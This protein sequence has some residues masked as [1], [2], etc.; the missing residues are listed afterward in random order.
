MS[1]GPHAALAAARALAFAVLGLAAAGAPAATYTSASTPYSLIPSAGHAKLGYNTTPYRFNGP[2]NCGTVPP[3]L[4][5][6]ISDPIPIGFPFAFGTAVH[7][8]VRVMTN[9]RV[10][11]GNTVC[12][13]GTKSIGPPQTYPNTYPDA[14]MNATMKVFGV[15]LDP[16]NLVDRPN[17]PSSAHR[18][19]C[20]NIASCYVSYATI[21]SAPTRRFVVTWMNVPEWVNTTNTSGSFDLQV[22]LD[23]D[24]SFV[25]Q[26][27][28]ISHGGTGTA[29]VGW[30]LTNA[31][32]EVLSF[33]ASSEPPPYTAIKFYLPAPIA[34]HLFD[35]GAWAPGLAGQVLD[36]TASRHGSAL[37][38]VQTTSG[39][40]LCRAASVPSN[41]SAAAVD[42]VRTGVALTDAALSLLGK[43]TVAFWYRANTAWSGAG[44][45]AAQ[46]LDATAVSGEWFYLAKTAAGALVFEVRD[47]AGTTRAVTSAAQSFAA[48]TWVHVAVTWDF[49][50]NPGPNQDRLQIFV[51][52]GMPA[53]SA[54][55]S[56]GLVSS[57]VGTLH[58]GDNPSGFSGS[59]GSVNS[60]DG[61]VDEVSIYNFSLTQSQLNTLM[62][63][64]RAC[65]TP[66][67]DHLRLQHASGSGVTCTPATLTI[68]AC[69][70]A[71][72]ATPY[73]GGVAGTLTAAGTPTVNFDG[74]TGHGAGARFVIPVGAGSV[75]KALQVT[76]PGSIVVGTNGLSPAASAATTCNFGSPACSFTAA[77]SG[78]VFSVPDHAADSVQA[79]SVSAVRTSP[80][81]LACTPAFASVS[82]SITFACAYADPASGTLPVLLGGTALNAAGNAAAACDTGGKAVSLAFDASGVAPTTLRYADVGRVTL[83]ARHAPTTG[84]EAGLV[85]QGS[86]AFVARPAAF[87][88]GGVR[89][90][91]TA[92]GHC[93]G[94]LAP[95]G[96]NP[97]AASAGGAAFMPAGRAFSATVTA[98]NVSGAA[99]PNFG[100]ESAPEGVVLVATL[101]QPAG[102]TNGTLSNATIA[103]AGFSAGAATVT[104]L[105]YG[106]VG[107]VTLTPA[108]ADGSYLG[109]GNISG[110]V[111]APIGRFVPARF[112]LS[113]ASVAHRSALACAPASTF[114]YLGETFRFALTLTAQNAGGGTTT[115]YAGAFARFDPASAAAWQ[116]TG[117]DGSTVF[118]SASGRLSLGSASGGFAN[119]VAANVTITAAALRASAPEGPFSAAFGIAPVDSDGVALASFDMASASGGANDR[120][121]LGTLALHFGRLR[122]GSAIGAADRALVLPAWVQHWNGSAWDTNT[123]DSCTSVPTAAVSFG[124]LRRTLTT[125][126]TAAS[127]PITFTAGAG[128]LRLAAPGG[129][130]S[131]SV[132]VA[133][134]LGSGA[135]DASCLQL[136]APGSGDAASAGAQLAHLRGAWCGSGNAFDPSARA[137]FGLQRTQDHVLYRRENY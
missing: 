35:E 13:F 124:N 59:A 71:A 56:S 75:S 10:Q 68:V 133:L 15:D 1:R 66:A 94:T 28:D 115:N 84:T 33:G 130:R 47:S 127:G 101:L 52:A 61:L 129:G 49:N 74:S 121:S 39:G 11:F 131:G 132:D 4:D 57:S 55:T 120:A 112:A 90:T 134:S 14:D 70:D 41:S 23:E 60:A 2:S 8:S 91:S 87:A 72:C 105:A 104:T 32:Y 126:D 63:T 135:A 76:T 36:S 79:L 122:L 17:Y 117:R 100:R 7:T 40:R 125:A 99:T 44:A 86:A 18:T 81:T 25:Y 83:S 113:G 37:G 106:E 107:I 20:T 19:P 58:V 114:S 50:G 3:V 69:A 65:S 88:I 34:S 54:F 78:F 48:N 128:S 97:G 116:L 110:P 118:G 96:L 16:T 45:R 111:S 77:D 31:D 93:A 137:S 22:I 67:I 27:G 123:L 46:L 43:G 82:K 103:G 42:A 12:D 21:G 89:C 136:W 73:T 80:Q 92:A 9:G 6:V 102:G 53:A 95:P 5:D 64:T 119:G 29:Q 85:M 108:I 62:N 30:Q 38:A 98:L 24:G 26:Y 109:S 51:N